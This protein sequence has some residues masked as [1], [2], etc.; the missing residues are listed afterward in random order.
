[1]FAI[2]ELKQHKFS[3]AVSRGQWLVGLLIVLV[4]ACFEGGAAQA[5][6][7]S[8]NDWRDLILYQIITDRF[9]NGNSSNDAVE[10][11]FAPADGFKIHGGDFAGAQ[12]K[13][14]YLQQLGIDGLWISPV[15]LNANAEYH[16][17]AARD[18]YAI[19]PHFGTMAELQSLVAACHARGM[20]VVLDVVLNHMGDLIDSGDAGY[21][22][23]KNPATYTLRW[24]GA[25][26]HAGFFNDLTKF[27][28]H[29]T[30][31]NYV[32][33]EQVL[34]ELAGL[35][36]IKTED[37]AVRTELIR[38]Y[39]WLID[40]TDCDGFRIDTVKHVETPF[41][42]AWTP[43]V[44]AHADSIGKSHFFMFGEAFDGDDA[45]NGSYTGTVGGGPYKLDSMLYYPMYFTTS[46][47]F[48]NTNPADPGTAPARISDRYSYLNNYDPTSRE[49]L[50]NFLD[51]HDNPRFLAFGGPAESDEGKLRAALGWML[52]SRGVPCIYYGTEQGFDGGGDP[53]DREDM[54]RGSWDYGPSLGDNFNEARPLVQY[55][56]K[57][58]EVRRRHEA[59]RRGVT[60]E[61]NVAIA[62]SGQYLYERATATD[63]VW[64]LVNTANA[65]IEVNVPAAPWA[66]NTVLVDALQPDYAETVSNLGVLT[67]RFQARGVRVLESLASRNALTPQPLHV[68][69]IYPSHDSGINDRN[70]ALR[71][72]F[73]R[74]VAPEQ[75]PA[76]FT[77][78][79]FI[80]GAWQVVGKEGRYYPRMAWSAG[81]TYKW[82]LAATLTAR[83]GAT[84]PAR[85]EA[86]FI[87]TGTATGL[88]L[89]AGYVADRIARQGLSAPT[90]IVAA[91]ALGP[92]AM[93]LTDTNVSRVYTITPGGDIGHWLG[94]SR[95]TLPQGMAV[96]ADNK[97]TVI[98]NSGVYEVG[99]SRMTT[100]RI[101]GS[102]TT[103]AGATV[104]GPAA[105][106]S[107]LYLCDPVGNRVQ[108]LLANNT[109]Q[110]FATGING[111][112]GLAFG[113]GGAWGSDL[114]ASDANLAS[115]AGVA[116]GAGRIC[117]VTSAG[118]VSTFVL[119]AALLNGVTALAFDPTGAFGGNL[120]AADLINKRILQITP[121]GAI[122]VFATGFGGLKGAHCIAFGPDGALYVADAGSPQ[123]VRISR[124]VLTTDVALGPSSR[125]ALELAAAP[126]PFV[127]QVALR[128]TVSERGVARLEILDVAGRRVRLLETG[129]LEAGVRTIHWD[130]RDDGGSPST[131][132]LYFAHLSVGERSVV[133]RVVL[134]R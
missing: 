24:R 41:W 77:I 72:S 33:P 111:A 123:V 93:L 15:V 89:S 38:A 52:T 126:N 43:A 99:A 62:G 11:N 21:G 14:D 57:L 104:W 108:R 29:G 39:S 8:P 131:A 129:S 7:A 97:V 63:T 53:Y 17:Y 84:M 48:R 117:R 49:Q 12:A 40:Q 30:I 34:G 81:V 64:V 37:P 76:A 31:G 55:V 3:R 60:R 67:A 88:V 122:S 82:G 27:H 86:Q 74:D 65:P 102:S 107:L 20:V 75:L 132:G 79:P 133:K 9:A 35:D 125:S 16:G 105:F 127:G 91:P 66:P 78:T 1:M 19:A 10:G 71:V 23:F 112:S 128:F 2:K 124:A 44:R 25:K 113:P 115:I 116:D 119:N 103:Q 92:L 98:D 101:G 68:T 46:V 106:G 51:N 59:L 96:A 28:A 47:L 120:F 85:F 50:V 32:D 80:D 121:A 118:V 90:G 70:S 83:D 4:L 36:D 45:R 94:D 95:W 5:A 69:A 114:Y 130:G 58:S 109:L 13:L 18:L 110:P 26:H 22:T 134:S 56:R 61:I 6:T 87:T 100:Q 42:S 54:F 73:D